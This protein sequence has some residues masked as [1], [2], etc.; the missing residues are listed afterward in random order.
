M[1]THLLLFISIP[2]ISG[3]FLS[4]LLP[5]S[6][7][8]DS[9][10]ALLSLFLFLA[11]RN[12]RP[13]SVTALFLSIGIFCSLT[14]RLNFIPP[15]TPPFIAGTSTAL[16]T[17]VK[18]IPFESDDTTSLLLALLCGDKSLLSTSIQANFT[19]SGAAHILALSGLHLGL[20][21]TLLSRLLS[22]LGNY[23][24]AKYAR[25]TITISLCAI[26]T[27]ACGAGASLVRAFIFICLG[28]IG[29][30][31]PHRKIP[32]VN[33]LLFAGLLQLCIRPD[34]AHELSFQLSYLAC[35]GIILVFPQIRDW[36][37][38]RQGLS[39]GI[40]KSLSLS[41]SCQLFTA[42]LIWHTF[43][44]LPKYFLLT[45]LLALP[46]CGF[47]IPASVLT[48]TA[49][50]LGANPKA[51]VKICEFSASLLTDTLKTIASIP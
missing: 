32:A 48:I 13:L 29:K 7:A 49:S 46:I 38:T 15:H 8:I 28:S 24:V 34:F 14:A 4:S 12:G 45:N 44:T 10:F 47:L 2:F 36:H 5:D 16:K 51:L 43:G 25:C 18:S 20:I 35:A 3:I 21:A 6:Y 23:P 1:K 41:I 19:K 37:P 11:S 30:L 42:P 33:L 9:I 17:A 22:P 39:F 40:W 31:L 26:Y 50:A 27:L